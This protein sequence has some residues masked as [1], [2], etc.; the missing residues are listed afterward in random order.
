MQMYFMYLRIL[1]MCKGRYSSVIRSC[2]RKHL[3]CII[4]FALGFFQTTTSSSFQ[5]IPSR[6][7]S[8]MLDY[9]QMKSL[10]AR[11]FTICSTSCSGEM[12]NCY[13]TP[14]R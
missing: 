1:R 14:N 11:R 12:V 4:W 8:T 3:I 5:A 7:D 9:R 6:Q 13:W 10:C 2:F